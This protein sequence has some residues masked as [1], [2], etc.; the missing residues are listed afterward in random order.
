MINTVYEHESHLLSQEELD[1]LAAFSSLCCAI[2]FLVLKQST[3]FLIYIFIKTMY[4]TVWY[5][6]YFE[7]LI[8]GTHWLPWSHIRKKWGRKD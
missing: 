2:I 4:A 1:I 3:F 5:D 6:S 7:N 8:P